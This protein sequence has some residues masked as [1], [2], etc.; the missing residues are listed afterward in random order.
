MLISPCSITP[1]LRNSFIS[2]LTPDEVLVKIK[3]EEIEF[4]A[5]SYDGFTPGDFIKTC[6]SDENKEALYKYIKGLNNRGFGIKVYEDVRMMARYIHNA[7]IVITSSG[8]T[9]YEVAS[10][11]IPCI[12]ISQNERESRHLFSHI[13]KG[14]LNLNMAHSVSKEDIAD[15]VVGL[16]N[17]HSKENLE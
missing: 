12:S 5:E 10:L 4:E 17:K 16:I 1:D 7:D 11:G 6:Y 3:S 14:F 9:L 13:C 2:G 8:R 15:S